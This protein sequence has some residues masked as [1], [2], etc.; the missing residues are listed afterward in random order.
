MLQ[1]TPDLLYKYFPNDCES[2]VFDSPT[3]KFTSASK[4]N[5]INELQWNISSYFDEHIPLQ[6]ENATNDW[7]SSE[8]LKEQCD[9]DF[10]LERA[11]LGSTAKTN[12]CQANHLMHG[13][14]VSRVGILCFSGNPS[15][16][17]MWGHYSSNGSG[18][19]IGFKSKAKVIQ[20]SEYWG[21]RG[22]GKVKY[23]QKKL[24]TDSINPAF[25]IVAGALRKGFEWS[26][27]DE[28]RCLRQLP[29]G[30]DFEL[31][32]F[33]ATDVREII[34]GPNMGIQEQLRWFKM[35]IKFPLAALK[36]ATP[37]FE[38]F[39]LDIVAL[40]STEIMEIIESQVLS[41]EGVTPFDID[42]YERDAQESKVI[43]RLTLQEYLRNP[44]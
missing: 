28:Y 1:D 42:E 38:T 25:R 32:K 7:N 41:K 20:E 3:L 29:V 2:Y 34:L 11:G 17:A 37:S 36:V 12:I 31:F 30:K 24:T 13:S 22:P 40:P 26:Y 16:P 27:E 15:S 35:A 14:Y 4:L 9:L 8:D 6:I 43:S 39:N 10:F 5:D 19:C 33:R 18:V 21:L 23:H 44:D